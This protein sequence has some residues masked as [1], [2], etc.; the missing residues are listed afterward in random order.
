MQRYSGRCRDAEV[1]NTETDRCIDTMNK[2]YRDTDICK[3]RERNR[4]RDTETQR[5]TDAIVDLD[6]QRE[7]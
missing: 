1:R 4:C 3:E 2:R 7:M 6:I 5:D